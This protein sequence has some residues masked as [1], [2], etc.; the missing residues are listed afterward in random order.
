MLQ[1][2]ER[3]QTESAVTRAP[4]GPGPLGCI[5]VAGAVLA[6]VL[7]V[8]ATVATWPAVRQELRVSFTRTP[9]Q[10]VELFFTTT[11]S[12]TRQGTVRVPVTLVHHGAIPAPYVV[13]ARLLTES[14]AT[15]AVA[16]TVVTA[17]ARTIVTVVLLLPAP[18]ATGPRTVVVELVGRAENLHYRLPSPAAARTEIRR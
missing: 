10:Y 17:D 8:V 4:L 9:V 2:S 14:S 1:L 15:P 6:A 18:R 16:S 11:P 5:G 13:R 3:T 7:V 12:V